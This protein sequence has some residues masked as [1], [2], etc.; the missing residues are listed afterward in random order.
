MYKSL[1]CLFL[2]FLLFTSFCVKAQKDSLQLGDKYSEDQLY[3]LL[4]FNQMIDQPTSVNSSSFSYGLS[5]GYLKDIILNKQGSYSIA[6]GLGYNFDSFNHDLRVSEINST[7]TSS[8]PV[9]NTISNKLHTHN[10]EIPLEFR[11]RNSTAK[12]YSFWRIYGGIKTTLNL[13]NKFEYIIDTETFNYKNLSNYNTW[14]FGATLSVGYDT[15][16][17]HTYYALTP[18]LKNS[19]INGESIN[20]KILKIGVIFYML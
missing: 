9:S 5:A 4:S 12:K 3:L 13:V 8:N 20:T 10:L 14:Q 17:V 18:F 1:L 6:I 2:V 11:W 16:T 19:S 15:F 7:F